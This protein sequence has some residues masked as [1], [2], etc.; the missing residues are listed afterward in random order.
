MQDFRKLRV[1]Q[2]AHKVRLKAYLTVRRFPSDERFGL[3]SQLRRS[4]SSIPANIAESCGYR[5]GRDSAR[6]LY[7]ATGSCCET[8]DHLIAAGDLGYITKSEVSE[9]ESD[10]A[11]IRRMLVALMDRMRHSVAKT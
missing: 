5:G 1:W 9:L 10:L 3:T 7:I 11:S 6:F 4:A 8:L 2:L